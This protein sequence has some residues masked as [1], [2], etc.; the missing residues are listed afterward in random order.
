VPHL[1]PINTTDAKTAN[2]AVVCTTI[3]PAHRGGELIVPENIT[4]LPPYAPELNPKETLWEEFR[5][6][7]LKNYAIKSINEVHRKLEEAVLYVERDPRTVKSIT[8]FPY[9]AK[10]F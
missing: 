4:L 9:I 6:K 1:R 2:P 8:S 10:S 5:K 7:L 3:P